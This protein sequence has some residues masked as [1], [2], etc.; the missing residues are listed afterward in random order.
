MNTSLRKEEKKP[1]GNDLL[2]DILIGMSDGLVI[3]FALTAGLAGAVSSNPVIVIAGATAIVAGSIAMGVGG[4]MAGKASMRHDH[5]ATTASQQ[6]KPPAASD[7][8]K[9]DFFANIGLSEEM[10]QKAIEE[11]EKDK[12]QLAAAMMLDEPEQPAGD[13]EQAR[14]SALNIALSYAAGGLVPVIPYFFTTFPI[15]G[16]KISALITLLCLFGFGFFRS[17]IT[18]IHP[19]WGAIR[20]T[21]VG[22]LAAAAAYGAASLFEI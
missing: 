17:S 9:K 16:L 14:R 1:A 20:I 12:Q 8:R 6:E 4:Y 22:A 2:T 18:G 7:D 3:P 21:L 15:D 10:Q 19:W 13:T 5:P 11:M